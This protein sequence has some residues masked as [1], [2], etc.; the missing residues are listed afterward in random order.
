MAEPA[1]AE[2][3]E[4]LAQ[5]GG[6]G[7]FFAA[8]TAPGLATFWTLYFLTT[9]LHAVHVTAGLAVLAGLAVRVHR[10]SVVPAAPYPL[11]LG[12]MFW[13]LVDAIW[14]FVWPL[15]YL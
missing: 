3:F 4:T 2:Q 10:G 5:Q 15:F 12:A 14:I 1:V 11:A 13:H 8:H 7:L 6:A 9:G